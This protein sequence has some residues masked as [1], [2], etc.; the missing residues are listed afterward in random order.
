MKQIISTGIA[1]Y[2]CFFSILHNNQT[3][4]Q[5]N[6]TLNKATQ[7]NNY[8][9]SKGSFKPE[10]SSISRHTNPEWLRDA[11]FG[12]YTHFG[13]AVTATQHHTTEWWGWAMYSTKQRRWFNTVVPNSPDTTREFK[14]HREL[15]GDQNKFGYKDFILLFQPQKFD[16][17]EWA[18]LFHKAGARFAGPMGIHHDNFALWDSKVTRWNI[19]RTAGIDVVGD[20]EKAIRKRGM[21]YLITFHHAFSWW[22]FSHSYN[23][24]GGIPGNE[25]L[26]C[27]PHKFSEAPDSFEE[28]PDVEYEDLWFRKLAE[29]AQKYHPDLYWFDMGLELL[30]D[31]IRKKAFAYLLNIGEQYQQDIGISYKVKYSVCIPPSAGILDYEKGRST[32]LR[33]DVWLTDTP[34]GGWFYNG[35]KSRSAEAIIEILVDIVSKN[36]CLLLDVSPK[37][38]GTIPDDQKE[39]LLGIGEWLKMNGEAIY[40]TRPWKISGEGP[41]QLSSDGHFNENWDAIYTEKDIRFTR[42]KDGNTLYVI[43]LDRP[44]KNHVLVKQ[45]ANI[46]PWL[47]RKINSVK[48]LGTPQEEIEW[49]RD[50]EGLHLEFPTNAAGK[51][52]FCYQLK[53]Q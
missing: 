13:P 31:T 11:K 1:L 4:A 24:D 30:S 38:D 45:L 52:A 53:L 12:I 8:S 21:K 50:K 48:L 29:A 40:N 43:V 39:T 3:Y 36:G 6:T 25:D 19:K 34:L 47:D 49:T 14:L 46:Y 33:D 51:Y 26:Y 16:A 22:F 2:A 37:P 20:L 23:Y 27:R 10:W 44:S 17:E 42:S 32:G 35:Q 15:F 41:T 9:I 7:A 5:E 28:Y 18:D